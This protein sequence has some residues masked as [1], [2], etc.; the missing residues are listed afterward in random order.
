M[1]KRLS[2]M[3]VLTAVIMLITAYAVIGAP[4]G[5]EID[6]SQQYTG[7]GTSS[8][9]LRTEGGN[10]TNINITS[11]QIT[12]RWAG[13]F[14][15]I[16]AGLKLA[17]AGGNSFYEW[18][19]V[20]VSSGMVYAANESMSS[21]SLSAATEADMPG[22]LIVAEAAD[23]YNKTFTTTGDFNSSSM[24]IASVPYTTTWQG[25]ASGTLRTYALK[26][27]TKLVFAGKAVENATGFDNSEVDYQLLVPG[28]SSGMTYYFYFELP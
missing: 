4:S 16:T 20:N 24:D 21:W 10:L 26:T 2:K 28:F 23:N 6:A 15:T 17:D 11:D 9:F 3:F 7:T 13:F 27:G 14:G 19:V 8:E 25:G 18:S 1:T 22:N 12:S 5:A